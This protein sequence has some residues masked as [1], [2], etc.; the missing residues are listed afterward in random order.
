MSIPPQLFITLQRGNSIET[1]PTC[2]RLIYWDEIMK[3]AAL[4][5][6]EK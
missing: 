1:C 6:G 5:A 2:A 4:E 3:E